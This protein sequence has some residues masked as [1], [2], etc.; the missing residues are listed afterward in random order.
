MSSSILL[1]F[2]SAQSYAYDFF[3]AS[4]R[5]IPTTMSRTERGDIPIIYWMSDRLPADLTPQKRCEIVSNRLQA[6]QD[7]QRLK[8]LSTGVI[9]GQQ[10]IC[11]SDRHG[12]ACLD[13]LFTLIPGSDPRKILTQLLDLRGLSN[14]RAIEQGDDQRIY[15]NFSDY[16]S[17]I[18]AHKNSLNRE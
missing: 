11:T 16:T 14:G 8:Y 17:R 7:N 10:V 12:G 2:S 1:F 9:N 5:N 13:T 4:V 3:C 6:A 18:P 15:I